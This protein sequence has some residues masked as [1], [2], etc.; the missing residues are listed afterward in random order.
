MAPT[1]HTQGEVIILGGIGL[2]RRRKCIVRKIGIFARGKRL[3]DRD[4][5]YAIPQEQDAI[6]LSKLGDMI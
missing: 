4:T 3:R 2:M 6:R 1:L 5:P